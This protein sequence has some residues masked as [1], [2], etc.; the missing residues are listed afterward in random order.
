MYV[1]SVIS[2][3]NSDIA[4]FGEVKGR[5]ILV[6]VRSDPA[7]PY[8]GR[9]LPSKDPHRIVILKIEKGNKEKITVTGRH[10]SETSRR[11]N[12]II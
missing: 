3:S 11:S 2:H 7:N 4:H 9:L 10:L 8:T 12:W 6:V 5:I 1:A